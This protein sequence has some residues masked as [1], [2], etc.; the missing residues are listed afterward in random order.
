MTLSA[1]FTG[2]KFATGQ[3]AK[4]QKIN[5]SIK[6]KHSDLCRVD[7]NL[8]FDSQATDNV[9]CEIKAAYA[10]IEENYETG[11][12]EL[13]V[14]NAT[15]AETNTEITFT[16]IPFL[17]S[18]VHAKWYKKTGILKFFSTDDSAF[19]PTV[20]TRALQTVSMKQGGTKYNSKK[21]IL[22][23]LG[24][25]PFE[26]ES[27]YHY[28]DFRSIPNNTSKSWASSFNDAR[29]S[30]NNFCGLRGYLATITS[31]SENTFLSDRFLTSEGGLP[32][33]WIGGAD[34]D[35]EGEWRWMDG[36][37]QGVK[38][39]SGKTT[40]GKPVSTIGNDIP[41]TDFNRVF[42]DFDTTITDLRLQRTIPSDSSVQIRFHYWG[43]TSG[44][45]PEPNDSGGEDYLQICG[46]PK[47]NGTWNDLNGSN[48]CETNNQFNDVYKVCGYYVEWGGRP[49]ETDPG[50]IEKRVVDVGQ[51]R[52]YCK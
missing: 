36:P 29:S 47:G 14:Q 4:A 41:T 39:Y 3:T 25:V 9:T 50:L 2:E 37:E 44:G 12:D 46:L 20:W 11:V 42:V 22:F 31:Q 7:P 26:T 23:S 10:L 6:I 32:R 45:T 52:D 34:N 18:T 16:D 27:G 13:Y 30:S 8:T 1:G 21:K 43:V 28:Y 15:R 5:N 17:P 19:E 51:V 48:S 38:F 49:G 35:T 33:G 40:T 24:Y